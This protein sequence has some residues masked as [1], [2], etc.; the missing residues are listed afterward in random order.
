M[1]ANFGYCCIN[2]ELSAQ[3]VFTNRGM[4][5]RTFQ[6]RGIQ[7]ASQ[8]ALLNVKDLMTILKWNQTNGVKLFR[9]SSSMF[10][11]MSE[12]ELQDLPDYGEIRFIL[13]MCGRFAK[14][15]DIRL[16]MHPGPFNV[17]ASPNES[18]VNNTIKELDQHSQIMD[19]ME[20][21]VNQYNAINV[22]VNGVYGDKSKTFD[23]FMVNFRRL[24]ENTQNR[25][26]L[27]NDDKTGQWSILDLFTELRKHR[28]PKPCIVFDYL[29]HDCHP[30]T[31][32]EQ[33]GLAMASLTWHG[34][35]QLVHYSSSRQVTDP[36]SKKL[37]HADYVHEKIETYIFDL[38]VE[39]EAKA[40]E[41][42]LK[43]YLLQYEAN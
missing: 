11:W 39:L 17:L 21:E 24:D 6:S 18:T 12:Y 29:H 14:R 8:L 2:L 35:R 15:H 40:K 9:I 5:K 33:Q 3:G 27:E 4:I 10:P 23:R 19:L 31:L 16:V 1:T 7:Y 13:K 30:D 41:Q 28:F 37:A 42:A 32:S 36:D 20:L 43:Q 34:I 26:T 25:L 22:H 38:D